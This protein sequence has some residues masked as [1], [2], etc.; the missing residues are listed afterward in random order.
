MPPTRFY[1]LKFRPT[2]LET[3]SYPVSSSGSPSRRF[4]A[5]RTTLNHVDLLIHLLIDLAELT[6]A[7]KL[8]LAVASFPLLL[9]WRL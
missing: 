9:L 5:S 7:P 4:T 1:T 8:L 2:P 6:A 3:E